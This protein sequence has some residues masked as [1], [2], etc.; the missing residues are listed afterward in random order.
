MMEHCENNLILTPTGL[1]GQHVLL[2]DHTYDNIV[3]IAHPQISIKH[4][5]IS[6]RVQV[7]TGIT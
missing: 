3:S 6:I 2:S 4:L 5:E 7:F 1:L